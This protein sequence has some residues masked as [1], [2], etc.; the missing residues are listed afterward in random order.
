[1]AR[2]LAENGE[3]A[4]VRL[5]I[6]LGTAQ[7]DPLAQLNILRNLTQVRN[8]AAVEVLIEALSHS[9][10]DIRDYAAVALGHIG[11]ERAIPHLIALAFDPIEWVRESAIKAI[12]DGFAQ[13]KRAESIQAAAQALH[14]AEP[15]VRYLGLVV[16]SKAKPVSVSPEIIIQIRQQ[17][18]TSE[19]PG[20]RRAAIKA[21]G[22]LTGTESTPY[23]CQLLRKSDQPDWT[24]TLLETLHDIGDPRAVETMV[25]T[26]RLRGSTGL[27]D[28]F[29]SP[30][31]YLLRTEFLS[32][33]VRFLPVTQ[34][35]V[36]RLSL[37][38]DIR[39]LSDG[40]VC[41]SDGRRLSHEAAMR[42]L[43]VERQG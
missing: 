25:E 13:I 12:R 3:V 26:L 15:M 17:L 41:L 18:E 19:T 27:L 39:V 43:K 40:S 16:L 10:D 30:W 20:V 35:L 2:V 9:M 7:K 42:W 38:H 37:A 14:H 22:K 36:A 5:L 11:D 29:T 8:T 1:L 34:P 33:L 4:S 21:L 24:I 6:E 28:M 32:E 23:V 31:R